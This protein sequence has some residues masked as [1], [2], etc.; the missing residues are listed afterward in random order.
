MKRGHVKKDCPNPFKSKKPY[1]RET[2]EVET[3][4]YMGTKYRRRVTRRLESLN[5]ELEALQSQIT[6]DLNYY[7]LLRRERDLFGNDDFD[8]DVVF[9]EEMGYPIAYLVKPPLPTVPQ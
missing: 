3:T 9:T 7:T 4:Q 1:D 8:V 5:E 2:K 6:A